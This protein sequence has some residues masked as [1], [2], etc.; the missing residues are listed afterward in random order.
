[1]RIII[2]HIQP[3]YTFGVMIFN[4]NSIKI[5]Q[6]LDCVRNIDMDKLSKNVLN[7]RVNYSFQRKIGYT[8]IYEKCEQLFKD[9]QG[10]KRI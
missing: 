4:E 3:N 8:H 6:N 2:N 7:M 10:Q 9:K 5:Y 1:M